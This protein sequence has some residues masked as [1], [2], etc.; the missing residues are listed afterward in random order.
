M[1]IKISFSYSEK[2]NYIAGILLFIIYVIIHFNYI[3]KSPIWNPNDEL[4]HV[5]YI[6]RI[7]NEK[8]FVKDGELISDRSF[9]FHNDLKVINYVGFDGKKEHLFI[10]GNSYEAHQPPI[11]YLLMATPYYFIM[12]S[13]LNPVMK[14]TL[15]RIFS[16]VFHLLGIILIF[17][18]FKEINAYFKHHV[19]TLDFQL[20]TAL[21]ILI[22]TMHNRAGIN[23]DQLNLLAVN[24]SIYFTIRY[25][26]TKHIKYAFAISLWGCISFFIKYT[27]GLISLIL[28]IFLFA[29]W[30]KTIDKKRLFPLVFIPFFAIPLFFI[31]SGI[32]N[33]WNNILNNKI[34]GQL[35]VFFSPGMLSFLDFF[36]FHWFEFFNLEYL[37]IKNLY[38]QYAGFLFYGLAIIL[39][40]YYMTRRKV[41]IIWTISLFITLILYIIILLLSNY[42]CCVAWYSIR[43]YS[44]YMI[45]ITLALFGW[46]A[47]DNNLTK[48][49]RTV[50]IMFLFVPLIYFFFKN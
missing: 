1:K 40:I 18:I 2:R 9:Q 8:R 48:H 37:G 45:F 24:L 38:F 19:F 23:N 22:T 50:V 44:G 31:N 21:F 6:D 11:Y 32:Q 26:K 16:Y 33:G 5:D 29:E 49:L 7:V 15:L 36:K 39:W 27:N 46:L 10:I 30:I 42:V 25:L 13:D 43:L 35:F 20:I 41:N 12:N 28:G 34:N 17:A 4:A 47:V 3:L 14:L